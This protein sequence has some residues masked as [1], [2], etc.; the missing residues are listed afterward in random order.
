LSAPLH[1]ATP[2]IKHTLLVSGTGLNYVG[3]ID[4]TGKIAWKHDEV[5]SSN[6]QKND[7]W[8]LP[9]GNVVYSYQWGIRIVNV[10][11]NKVIWD[12]PTPKRNNQTGEVHSCQPLEGGSSKFLVGECFQDTAFI[13]EVDTA[14]KEWRRIPLKNQG[15]GTHGKW[16]QIRKTSQNTYLVSSMDL[17]RSFEYDTTGKL[18]HE[19]PSGG[20]FASR[21]ENGNTLTGTG[22]DCRFVEF[23]ASGTK[24]W[25]VNNSTSSVSGLVIG[26]GS[27]AQRLP[28]G[29]T[30]ITNWGGHGT[31]SGASVVE[32]KPDRTVVG[33]LPSSFPTQ[34]ASVK[35][36]DGWKF[37]VTQ[38]T[39]TARA[40]VNGSIEPAGPVDVDS[41]SGK[42]FTFKAAD[43][44]AVDSVKV[45]GVNKGAVQTYTFEK[46]NAN[47]SIEVT[48]K[49]TVSIRPDLEK[50]QITDKPR[51]MVSN[52]G[53]LYCEVFWKGETEISVFDCKGTFLIRRRVE[54][55]GRSQLSGCLAHG[56]YLITLKNDL[57]RNKWIET[58]EW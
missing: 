48:F 41:G 22:G 36:I 40:S 43:G 13:V 11:T 37:P 56:M 15:G 27:E 35:V 2:T 23:D 12:R 24:I 55:P 18:V 21:L 34:I 7:C 17:Y 50:R 28:N 52:S 47:H 54:G 9:N 38:F 51:I 46:L 45:D 30:I 14:K 3:I 32:I 44:Y 53:N 10:R 31:G 1:A 26:F 25:E 5:E 19:F 6:G 8:L 4:S 58:V 49:K 16:R 42:T 20:Y 57:Q 39:I 29:N 33:A